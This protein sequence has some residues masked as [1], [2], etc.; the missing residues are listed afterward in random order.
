MHDGARP[1]A[2]ANVGDVEQLEQALN[3]AVFP[4]GAVKDREATSQPSRPHRAR[5]TR[6]PV[7]APGAVAIERTS[8]GSWPPSRSPSMTEAPPAIETSCSEERPPRSTATF[9]V[10]GVVVVDA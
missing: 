3:R 7:D 5:V 9:R 2:A 6:V 1:D 8:T 4:K 10:A